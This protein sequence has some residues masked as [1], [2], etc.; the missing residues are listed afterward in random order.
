MVLVWLRKAKEHF[1]SKL[2]FE[3]QTRWHRSTAGMHTTYV[4]NSMTPS[5]PKEASSE[6]APC[7]AVSGCQ[8]AKTKLCVNFLAFCL[9]LLQ[10]SIWLFTSHYFLFSFLHSSI[11]FLARRLHNHSYYFGESDVFHCNTTIQKSIEK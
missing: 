7:V 11:S 4:A 1:V 9:F 6:N 8:I 3:E 2:T 10:N 5:I